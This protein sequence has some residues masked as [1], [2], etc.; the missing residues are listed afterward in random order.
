MAS[1]RQEAKSYGNDNGMSGLEVLRKI[2]SGELNGVQ[3]DGIWYVRVDKEADSVEDI[4]LPYRSSYETTRKVSKFISLLGWVTFALG[5][6]GAVMALGNYRWGPYW[7]ALLAMVPGLVGVISGLF[8]VVAG[9]VSRATVD[10]ADHTREI[11]NV[12]RNKN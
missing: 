6:I 4:N 7:G 3:D 11:L 8:L 5:L 12:L 9:Q 2:K 10:N 1:F